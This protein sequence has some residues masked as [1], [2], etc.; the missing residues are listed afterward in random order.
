MLHVYHGKKLSDSINI[1]RFPLPRLRDKTI[2]YSQKDI[3][4][5]FKVR[6]QYTLQGGTI[7]KNI[8]YLPV[9]MGGQYKNK[10]PKPRK[11]MMIDLE[12]ETVTK[13]IDLEHVIDSEPEDVAFYHKK[14]WLF[15]GQKGGLYHLNIF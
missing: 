1:Y 15:C 7:Q 10:L 12:Q 9:G 13:V 11:L 5:A 8:L 6:V 3:E 2:C 14:L 4:S